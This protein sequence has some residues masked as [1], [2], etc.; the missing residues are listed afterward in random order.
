MNIED[1]NSYAALLLYIYQYTTSVSDVP[2]S[3]FPYFASIATTIM[4]FCS[5]QTFTLDTG[6][7]GPTGTLTKSLRRWHESGN[8]QNYLILDDGTEI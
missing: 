4:S 3:D 2:R 5:I 7:D 1:K 6:N 8:T